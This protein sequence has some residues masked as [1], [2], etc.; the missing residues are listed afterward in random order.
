MVLKRPASRKTKLWNE[1][2]HVRH[3][4]KESTVR[5]GQSHWKR[6]L[7][8]FINASDYDIVP[9]LKIDGALWEREGVDCPH[10]GHG[11]VSPVNFIKPA[12]MEKNWVYRCRA[13]TCQKYV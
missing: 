11:K 6:S 13:K 1:V 3:G 4:W 10:C 12:G 9:L 2:A 5:T 7:I 8:D